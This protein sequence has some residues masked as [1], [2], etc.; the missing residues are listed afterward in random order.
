M[1]KI[2]DI[3]TE[4]NIMPNLQAHQFR[5]AG[6]ASQ[7]CNSLNVP[8]DTRSVISACLLHDMGNIIKFHL[9]TFPEF[10]EPEG[11][12]YWQN[13]Q[14]EY[15][16]R[17]GHDEHEATVKIIQELGLSEDIVELAN[18]NRFS[19]LCK[20]KESDNLALKIIHYADARVGPHGVL[21]Y[22][23]RMDDAGVRYANH[24]NSIEEEKR[25]ALVLCGKEI[26]KQIFSHSKIKPEDINDE[27]TALYM[28][29]L[30]NFEI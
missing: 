19:W 29:D 18:Q 8:I 21:S 5:V 9:E 23:E 22:D 24:K 11:L 20:H 17:Y 28:E 25:H 7:V 4:Y 27:S 13:I 1:K 12:T 6:V 14:N 16:S 2:T 15:L 30:K 3:Y 26:E 10:L